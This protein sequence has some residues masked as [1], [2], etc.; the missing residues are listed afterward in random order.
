MTTFVALLMFLQM[1]V[2]PA[3][4]TLLAALLFLPWVSKSWMR[5]YVYRAGHY[6]RALLLLEFFLSLSLAALAFAL[7]HSLEWTFATLMFISLLTAGHEFTSH[8][9]YERM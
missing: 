5:S 9:Y 7:L 4:S 3:V 2:S 8:L 1:G 6:R